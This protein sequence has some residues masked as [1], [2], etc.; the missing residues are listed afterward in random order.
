MSS[1]PGSFDRKA[2]GGRAAVLI[3][4]RDEEEALPGLLRALAAGGSA[5]R[6]LV[7]D[8]GSRDA[9]AAAA[10]A[11]GAEVVTE[12]RPGY[13]RACRRGIAALAGRGGEPDVLVV[14]DADD[15]A[16]ARQL[17]RLLAP[18]RQGRADL[19]IGARRWEEGVPLHAALGNWAVGRVLCGL[20]GLD[21]RDMGPFRAVRFDLLRRLELDDPDFGWN[22]QMTV[23]AVR[24][25]LR[26]WEV[27]V[28]FEPRAEGTSKITGSWRASLRAGAT[29]LGVLA[30]EVLGPATDP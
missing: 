16:A 15:R 12:P 3:P 25:G 30:A 29:M 6:V 8:N 11:E 9:T 23:R 1:G 2:G 17:P 10:R 27:P 7:V 21:L 5:D 24:A 13:G 18:L 26:T 4:A 22:V 19:V 20:Y 28:R 14:L